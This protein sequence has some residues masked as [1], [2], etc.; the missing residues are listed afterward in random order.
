[1]STWPATLPRPTPSGYSIKPVDQTIRTDME[2]GSARVRRRTSS[3]NDK[4]SVVWEMTDDQLAIFRTWFDNPS[5]AAGG[6]AWFTNSLALG[7]TGVVTCE[8]RFT[9]PPSIQA[10]GPITWSVS[11][12]LE[13]R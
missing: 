2:G 13:V 12:E 1:M 10:D 7:T 4:V 11:A 5:E 9:G 6:S 8:T 3:R